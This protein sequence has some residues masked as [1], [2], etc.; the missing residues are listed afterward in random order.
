MGLKEELGL[1]EDL[2]PKA[3]EAILNVYYTA[4][5]LKK[6]ARGL[7]RPFGI[8]D[9]Q[10]NV[11][12]LLAYHTDNQ[13]GLTQAELGHMMLVNRANITPLVDRMEKAEL[14]ARSPVPGDRRYHLVK[15][16]P[17]GRELLAK[18]EKE[19][20]DW[21]HT[22][23]GPVGEGEMNAL[24][25]DLGILRQRIYSAMKKSAADITDED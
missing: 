10:F 21:S 4:A 3:H 15:L 1:P 25:D 9:V 11:M 17:R 13:G 7:F 22:L 24:V 19:Y 5:L 8:T 18:V 2:T 12:Q 23:M 6:V 20:E 16:T 14:V